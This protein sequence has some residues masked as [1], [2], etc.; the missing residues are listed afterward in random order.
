MFKAFRISFLSILICCCGLC[1][2]LS[3]QNSEEELFQVTENAFEDGFY[4]TARGYVEQLFAQFPKT[5]KR[6]PARLIQGQCYFF[7]SQYLKAYDVFS[8]LLPY[9]EYKDATLYWLGETLFKGGDN[10]KAL[11]YYRQLLDIY[12]Q[13]SYIPQAL[14]SLGWLFFGE[15]NW[16]EAARY[17]SRFIGAY[18][19]HPL[20]E[21]SFFKLAEIAFLQKDYVKAIT[22]FGHYLDRFSDSARAAEGYFYIGES[23]YYQKDYLNAIVAYAKAAQDA[24]DDH[25]ALNAETGLGWAYLQLEKFQMAEEAFARAESFSAKTG[26]SSE[27]ILL[28]EAKLYSQTRQNGKALEAYGKLIDGLDRK[29]TRLN[30]SHT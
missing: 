25:L 5:P 21:E 17:F 23:L 12:P 9:N 16:N 14:Y 6:I 8:E 27:D 24:P 2:H 15:K 29:S 19:K 26:D 30:S 20:N 13:S 18:P 10:K 7:R 3:A 11:E 28:G 22:G 1:S 4:D